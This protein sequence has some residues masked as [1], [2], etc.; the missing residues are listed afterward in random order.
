MLTTTR[1]FGLAKESRGSSVR[2]FSCPP[3][4]VW[5]Q[6]WGRS[7]SNSPEPRGKLKGSCQLSCQVGTA[8]WEPLSR[9]CY[10]LMKHHIVCAGAASAWERGHVWLCQPLVLPCLRG[11]I[12]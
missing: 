9:L 7:P 3:H 11:N 10:K 4:P 1:G 12:S 2:C 8:G 6:H 5:L